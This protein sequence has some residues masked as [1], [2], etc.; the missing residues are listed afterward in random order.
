MG[1]NNAALEELLSQSAGVRIEPLYHDNEICARRE[2]E[3]EKDAAVNTEEEEKPIA[4]V[5]EIEAEIHAQIHADLIG[6]SIGK[7]GETIPVPISDSGEELAVKHLLSITAGSKEEEATKVKELQDELTRQTD[8][9]E[10]P[11]N[12]DAMGEIIGESVMDVKKFQEEYGSV[13]DIQREKE[14]LHSVV[15]RDHKEQVISV[16][17]GLACLCVRMCMWGIA[18]IAVFRIVVVVLGSCA[19]ASWSVSALFIAYLLDHA[20]LILGVQ[21]PAADVSDLPVVF[22]VMTDVETLAQW[23]NRGNCE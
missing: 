4:D 17:T 8:I 13:L 15:L 21:T 7:G 18:L 2:E 3:T 5:A 6:I 20:L 23:G 22:D 14:D 11:T 10:T 1:D 16:S 9:V 19:N 12:F